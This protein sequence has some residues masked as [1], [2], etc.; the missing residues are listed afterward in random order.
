MLQTVRKRQWLASKNKLRQP[1]CEVNSQV[2][3]SAPKVWFYDSEA[4]QSRAPL[5]S[6]RYRLAGFVQQH[7]SHVAA[8]AVA[9]SL[10][11]FQT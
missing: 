5:G 4:P 1:E 11:G 10:D 6:V 2:A 8:L 7:Q 3:D 9:L